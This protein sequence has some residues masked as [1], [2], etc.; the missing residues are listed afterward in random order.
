MEI[1]RFFINKENI[2]DD[3]VTISGDEFDHIVKVLR[4]KVGFKIIVCS[5]DKNDIH[6]T[7]F[8]I[9]KN[10]L[11]AKIDSI[12]LNQNETKTDIT[13]FQSISKSE[14]MDVIV[15]KAVELGVKKIIPFES[16]FSSNDLRPERLNKIS[17]EACKQCGRAILVDVI[18]PVKF[19][20][21]KEILKNYD[22][23][24]VGYENEDK[25]SFKDIDKCIF[26]KKQN[27]CNCRF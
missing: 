25:L 23:I 17:Y 13:L 9:E 26:K 5:G 22:V 21:L 11:L 24:L 19:N 27:C 15:Q 14:K 16:S 20:D 1:R 18:D 12:E 2:K 8:K 7:I 4:H 6:C 3:T 10:Y